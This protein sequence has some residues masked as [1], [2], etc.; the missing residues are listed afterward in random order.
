VLHTGLRVGHTV[1]VGHADF[2]DGTRDGVYVIPLV[3]GIV[4]TI[5]IGVME[6][7]EGAPA[8]VGACEGASVTIL[9]H[10]VCPALGISP[11]AQ[12]MHTVAFAPEIEPA[13]HFMHCMSGDGE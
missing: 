1:F 10:S 3:G 2:I 6:T 5:E 8:M 4:S 7:V 9:T 12:V 13:A 11:A